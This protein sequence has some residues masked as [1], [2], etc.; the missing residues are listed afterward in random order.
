MLSFSFIA[1]V[2]QEPRLL[3]WICDK[4]KLRERWCLLFY[5]M[6]VLT[7]LFGDRSISFT[8]II[9]PNYIIFTPIYVG[10]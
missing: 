1:M 4:C 10:F 3:I 9:D 8:P 2:F 7:T 6:V 5:A